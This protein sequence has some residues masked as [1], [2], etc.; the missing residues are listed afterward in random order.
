MLLT[1]QWKKSIVPKIT[2]KIFTHWSPAKYYDD[3]HACIDAL[4]ARRQVSGYVAIRHAGNI[5]TGYKSSG[6]FLAHDITSSDPIFPQFKAVLNARST[7]DNMTAKI[8]NYM[9]T[10]M[11]MC[12]T[13]E[14]VC[15]LFPQFILDAINEIHYEE[16]SSVPDMRVMLGASTKFQAFNEKN[17]PI[18]IAMK[19][20]IALNIIMP[21]IK[22][23]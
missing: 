23:A 17:K 9:L 2:T 11:A 10:G 21:D 15:Q 20:Q 4:S 16:G 7:Y 14:C 6:G 1:P 12:H 13:T 5:Y 8:S 3:L 18:I 19:K 22:H